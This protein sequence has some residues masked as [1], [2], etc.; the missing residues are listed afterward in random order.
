MQ[1]KADGGRNNPNVLADVIAEH[2][3]GMPLD[4]KGK[5]ASSTLEHDVPEVIHGYPLEVLFSPI[6]ADIMTREK[7]GN[8]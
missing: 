4:F 5:S 3:A 1:V 2:S 8:P 7:I 6:T